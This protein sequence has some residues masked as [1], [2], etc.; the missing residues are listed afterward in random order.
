MKIIPFLFIFYNLTIVAQ[1]NKIDKKPVNA[2][3]G[4]VDKRD[5]N[6]IS[7]IDRAKKDFKSKEVYYNIMPNGY[8]DKDYNR[9]FP[10]LTELLKKKGIQFLTSP[11]TDDDSYWIKTNNDSYQIKTNC[12]YKASNELLNIKY[13]ANF[14]KNIEKTADSLYV[15]SRIN[16]E[17]EYPDEVD[18]YCLIY[19]KANEF[20]N[21]KNEIL[22][23]F[24]SNFKFSNGFVK[25]KNKRDFFAKTKFIIKR[26]NSVTNIVIDIKFLNIEN[27]KFENDIITQLRNY[28]ENANWNAAVASGIKIN[29]SFEMNFYN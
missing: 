18:D 10:F 2:I 8:I 6:C 21:Q 13:G 16:D 9:S 1:Q 4:M 26:D 28:I 14:T 29:S 19:P 17:F 12:Y 27:Q 24:I 20:L 15:M 7:E 11:E 5:N 3:I 25:S 22:K 23:D